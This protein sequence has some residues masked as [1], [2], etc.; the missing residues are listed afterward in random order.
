[1]L[2]LGLLRFIEW[3]QRTRLRRR[4]E[5]T[6]WEPDDSLEHNETPEEISSEGDMAI[7][8]ETVEG[9]I[10]P[11]RN[12]PSWLIPL[13]KN[14][15]AALA[16]HED[17]ASSTHTPEEAEFKI[18]SRID[19]LDTEIITVYQT[20]QTEPQ[21]EKVSD[22]PIL[23]PFSEAAIEKEAILNLLGALELQHHEGKVSPAFYQRKRK[24]LLKRLSKVEKGSIEK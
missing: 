22:V 17:I 6:R 8:G 18:Q 15:S 20:R 9:I 11:D 13:L 7:P 12:I 5:E 2:F 10:D 23:K 14:R 24:Q 4:S 3:R 16:I 19:E 21:S 1:M